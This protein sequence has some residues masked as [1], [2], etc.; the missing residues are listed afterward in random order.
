M[1]KY[2]NPARFNRLANAILPWSFGVMAIAFAYG[3]YQ[4]LVAS[5][6]DYQQGETV[7]IM[8]IHVPSAWMSL[9]V[10]MVLASASFVSLVWRHPLADIA[11]KASAPVGA[12]FT[13][14]ALFTGSLWGKPMWGTYW[15]WDARMTSVLILLFLYFG[16]MALWRSIDD[17][18]KAAKAAAI[19]AIVGVINV[20]IIK[21]S[22][23]W[24]NTIHQ[25][26]SVMRMGGPTI[27]GSMLI[28]LFAMFI[29]FHAYFITLLLWRMKAEL[30]ERKIQI[31]KE[32]EVLGQ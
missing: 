19:L 21:F 27:D 17:Q 16:Y 28:P 24:W 7:R 15:E 18:Q 22:V 25:P 14:L 12:T 1:H 13:A 29:A 31:M 11:A 6:P 3:L 8:Y 20:P 26:A 9:A 23:E 4:A 2:A 32:N 10:Y 5:P 30:N